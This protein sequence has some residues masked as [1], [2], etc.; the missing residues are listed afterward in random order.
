M[1]PPKR[2]VS[3]ER[4]YDAATLTAETQEQADESKHGSKKSDSPTSEPVQKDGNSTL[5][6]IAPSYIKTIMTPDDSSFQRLNCPVPNSDRYE[7]LR[8]NSTNTPPKYFFALDLH[9]CVGVLPRLM[10]SIVES[11]LFLGPKNCAL[12]V[13]EGRS[14]DGTFEVLKLLREE[15]EG[16]GA[17]YFFESNDLDPLAKNGDR[18][19]ALAELRNRAV[20]PLVD[21]PDQY[22]PEITVVFIND[23]ALCM[24]DILELLHQ[25]LYQNADM[26]CA[27][28]WTYIGHDPTFYDL[29]IARDMN[30]DSF[31]KIPEDGSWDYAWNL[32]WDNP[33]AQEAFNEK[34]PFQ[35]FSCWNGATA[36]TARPLLEQ[37]I[38]FRSAHKHECPSGEPNIF[39]KEMWHHGYRKIAVVPSINLEYSDKG[40]RKIKAAKGFVSN[41][42]ASEGVNAA[43][44]EW[45][46]RPPSQVKCIP[47]YSNQ[48]WVAWDHQLEADD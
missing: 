6:E 12:S 20:K 22:S 21:H 3:L 40:A 48:T 2:Q 30:G 24:E 32:F 38:R 23:V 1:A 14:D 19:R 44:I 45:E 25:R 27:I 47:N 34:R 16:I 42:V 31:F 11:M 36:F 15:I 10:G 28:D 5:L 43:K 35:V 41:W 46:T 39:C 18:V 26:I 29:W 13:V 8:D 4:D 9:Q 17:R 37:K 33:D 7:Y